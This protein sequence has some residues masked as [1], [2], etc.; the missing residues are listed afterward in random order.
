MSRAAS[1][2]PRLLAGALA[3]VAFASPVANADPIRVSIE[4]ALERAKPA[5]GSLS[6]ARASIES[7]RQQVDSAKAG[8]LPQLNATASYSRTLRSE[9]DGI[10]L[11]SEGNEL[12]FGQ[13]NTWRAGLE[14]SQ[15]I[16]DG[17]RTRWAI[18]EARSGAESS[19]IELRSLEAQVVQ[20]A[21]E[22][23]Y[24]AA[25][26]QRQVDI[27]TA[28][29]ALAETTL[30]DTQLN[31]REG[32]APEF[33]VVRAEVARDN[34]RTSRLQ[35]EAQREIAFVRLKRLL[36][37]PLD[38]ALELTSSLD[39]AAE[40]D[41]DQLSA[42]V[43][44]AA[45][46][47]STEVHTAIVSAQQSLRLRK[48]QLSGAK[49][50]RLPSVSASSEF[51][52]VDYPEGFFP[53]NTDWRTNWTVGVSVTVPVFDGFRRRAVVRGARAEV[54]AAEARLA[55]VVERA[56]AE[57]RTTNADIT[58]AKAVWESSARTVSLAQRAYQ[59]AELRFA[60]GSSTHL[61][62]VDARLSLEEAQLNQAQAARD[63]RVARLR[64]ELL[65]G[66]PLGS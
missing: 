51:G 27:A 49:A 42:A 53:A 58:A 55:D 17:G 2:I 43:R 36:D 13:A 52:L 28:S 54:V 59:I 46:L 14:V 19:R 48:A 34:Q 65:D 56:L 16:Y 50:D 44:A 15:L 62:L 41:V 66:L 12:P 18:D 25:L 38:Q 3:T 21:A 9:Y 8:R 33:D 37:V 32:A 31:Y 61:E 60:Q 20:Q 22:A 64:H 5:S 47:A 26:A 11:G 24:D 40:A 29:L 30:A 23:Y 6:A 45:G 7:A 35:Y 10:S 4:E 63:L 39:I 1:L 57:E